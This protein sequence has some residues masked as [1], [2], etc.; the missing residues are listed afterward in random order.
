VVFL[1]VYLVAVATTLAP[2]MRAARVYPAEA[3][4]YQ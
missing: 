1:A 3:L 4:R 2:A